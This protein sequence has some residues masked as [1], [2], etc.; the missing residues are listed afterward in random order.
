MIEIINNRI[1][2][3]DDKAN[4]VE[5][6]D[7][8]LHTLVNNMKDVIDD[9]VIDEKL[10]EPIEPIYHYIIEKMYTMP[11]YS[12]WNDVPFKEKP[13][14]KLLIAFNKFLYDKLNKRTE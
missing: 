12:K 14:E 13:K 6:D 5:I 3:I 10:I 8:A 4:I 9:V 7:E 2:L 11:E 1:I